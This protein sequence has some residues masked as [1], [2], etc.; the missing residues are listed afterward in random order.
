MGTDDRPLRA[1]G[2][3]R[4]AGVTVRTLHHYDRLGLLS[5]SRRTEA[6]YRLYGTAD[7]ARLHQIT[8]LSLL[9]IPLK[10]IGDLLDRRALDLPAAL[11]MQRTL[12]L[13]RRRRLDEA[14]RLLDRAQTRV[15]EARDREALLEALEAAR[16]ERETNVEWVK[17]Y[18]TEEQMADLSSRWSPEV[19]AKAEKD[20][21]DLARDVEAA[22]GEDPAGPVAQALADRHQDLIGQ[23]TGGNPQ[24]EENL[25]RLYADRQSWPSDLPATPWTEAHAEFIRLAL[26]AR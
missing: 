16:M 3:A 15:G 11:R 6:G 26:A 2:F 12:L 17:G 24:I 14:L 5:P 21:A 19:Q 4:L 10:R 25:Q 18:Y 8:T 1:K 7:L 13:E 22:L 9:G 20:W 23:F